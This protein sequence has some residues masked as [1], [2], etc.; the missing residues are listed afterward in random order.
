MHSLPINQFKK[1]EEQTRGNNTRDCANC[2]GEF[3]EGEWVKHLPNC[4]NALHVSCIDTWFQIH[5]SCPLCKSNAY[6][7]LWTHLLVSHLRG[8]VRKCALCFCG[9]GLGWA[10]FAFAKKCS[11]LRTYQDRFCDG[12]VAFVTGH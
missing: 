7:K 5:S 6:N 4:P 1:N 11:Q 12:L 10:I 8:P 3:E 2:L 9:N